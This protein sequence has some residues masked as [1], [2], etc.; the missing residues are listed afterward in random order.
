MIPKCLPVSM[1]W[2]DEF[3][4]S[5]AGFWEVYFLHVH[6]FLTAIYKN[7]NKHKHKNKYNGIST[8]EISWHLNKSKKSCQEIIKNSNNVQ[9][10][11]GKLRKQTNNNKKKKKTFQKTQNKKS[12][13][14]QKTCAVLG[15]F[16]GDSLCFDEKTWNVR[17]VIE[18]HEHFGNLQ[19]LA[20]HKMFNF[21]T[22]HKF[23]IFFRKIRKAQ[24][25]WRTLPKHSGNIKK[26]QKNQLKFEHMLKKN[27]E[28]SW[29]LRKV[30]KTIRK[31]QLCIELPL[32]AQK[33]NLGISFVSSLEIGRSCC[34][35]DGRKV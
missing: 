12:G 8:T 4:P 7:K 18:D 2:Q 34:P 28:I 16:L 17:K 11:P 21:L 24:Y 3:S 5:V 33:S 29:N 27:Q 22:I 10:V 32:F 26:S 13:S 15:K 14:F 9:E 25:G 23:S 19:K 35:S 6:E 30:P 1:A 20:V 31:G